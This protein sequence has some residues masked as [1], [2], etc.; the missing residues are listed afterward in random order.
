MPYIPAPTFI[1]TYSMSPKEKS[2]SPGICEARYL[3]HSKPS[4]RQCSTSRLAFSILETSLAGGSTRCLAWDLAALCRPTRSSIHWRGRLAHWACHL[5]MPAAWVSEGG[6]NSQKY[7][8]ERQHLVEETR[9]DCYTQQGNERITARDD[10]NWAAVSPSVFKLLNCTF[11]FF[12][13]A[14]CRCFVRGIVRLHRLLTSHRTTSSS[15]STPKTIL[16]H[17]AAEQRKHTFVPWTGYTKASPKKGKAWRTHA[18]L[19]SCH[20]CGSL[21]M[22]SKQDSSELWESDP[23]NA[24]VFFGL[25]FVSEQTSNNAETPKK[26]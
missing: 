12:C 10:K 19:P 21:R 9:D 7:S 5:R 14:I 16:A 26:R 22:H 24:L 25:F 3:G 2:K 13:C 11:S 20:C 4:T 6:E 1:C 17:D 15:A 23:V 8:H 18:Y